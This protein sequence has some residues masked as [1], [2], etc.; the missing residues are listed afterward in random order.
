MRGKNPMKYFINFFFVNLLY[1]QPLIYES[2][3]EEMLCEMCCF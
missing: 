2:S 1:A 3:E